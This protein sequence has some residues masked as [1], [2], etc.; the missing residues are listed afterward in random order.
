MPFLLEYTHPTLQLANAN[1]TLPT[2]K[3]LSLKHWLSNICKYYLSVLNP[4]ILLVSFNLPSPPYVSFVYHSWVVYN[5][6]SRSMTFLQVYLRSFWQ[7]RFLRFGLK[8][9]LLQLS[10]MK[11]ANFLV[12]LISIFRFFKSVLSFISYGKWKTFW[13]N[14]F[15]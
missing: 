15:F 4:F 12:I 6:G 10:V 2:S 9:S 11:I 1:S 3:S 7:Q 13:E 14:S 5:F 8:T